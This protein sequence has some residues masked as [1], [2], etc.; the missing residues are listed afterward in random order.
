MCV[1]VCVCVCVCASVCASVRACV[2][3]CV[4]ERARVCACVCECVCVYSLWCMFNIV[5]AFIGSHR[6]QFTFHLFSTKICLLRRVL[7]LSYIVLMM[8]IQISIYKIKRIRL[9]YDEINIIFV[10][11]LA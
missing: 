4:C 6:A 10:A 1:C 3:M 7:L 2:C 8:I 9:C 11:Y 5:F